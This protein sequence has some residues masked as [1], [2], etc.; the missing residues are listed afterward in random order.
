MDQVAN[1][2]VD[3]HCSDMMMRRARE[4]TMGFVKIEAIALLLAAFLPAAAYSQSQLPP[5]AFAE[6]VEFISFTDLNGHIP[7]KMSIHQANGR[8]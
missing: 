2:A 6:N 8:W 3:R 5:G 1:F 4:M 7:F